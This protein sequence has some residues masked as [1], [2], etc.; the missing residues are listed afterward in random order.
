MPAYELFAKA[1]IK[2]SN[3]VIKNTAE[4]TNL[5]DQG[6]IG[7]GLI[8]E[9]GKI[10]EEE[11][12]ERAIASTKTLGS[13]IN[14]LKNSIFDL[15]S[16]LSEGIFAETVLRGVVFLSNNLKEV[17]MFVGIIASLFAIS[18]LTTLAPLI[19]GA[20][21]SFG[22]LTISILSAVGALAL[23]ALTNPLGIVL[24]VLGLL[25]LKSKKF[26]DLF[27]NLIKDI[28]VIVKWV[29]GKIMDNVVR[30]II[31]LIN[32]ITKF[33]ETI[34]TKIG[35][36]EKENAFKFN[37]TQIGSLE[38]KQQFGFNGTLN[39]KGAPPGTTA[40]INPFD[41]STNLGLNMTYMGGTI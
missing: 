8:K 24:T 34:G 28:G 1:A 26:R 18:A 9:A 32:K 19:I 38:T 27:V 16:E 31:S 41:T 5:L 3:G 14:R 22:A 7:A 30:P 39:I 21:A 2:A 35:L 25:I 6:R 11:F 4:F 29:A 37:M 20:A 36:F 33:A 23:F 40:E 10:F 15:K 12:G 13:E 17:A